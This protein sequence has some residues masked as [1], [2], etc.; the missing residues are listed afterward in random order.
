MTVSGQPFTRRAASMPS[1]MPAEKAKASAQV[2][3]SSVAGSRSRITLATGL[4]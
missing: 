4:P 3:N 1:T 2:M